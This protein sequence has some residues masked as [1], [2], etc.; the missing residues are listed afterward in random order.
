M[1]TGKA[2]I[3]DIDATELSEGEMAF[4]WL[5]QHG[6]VLKLGG[7]V[8]YLDPYLS[9]AES[10]TVRPLLRPEEIT[11]ADVITGSHDHGDHI[12]RPVWAELAKASPQAK[13]VAPRLI[14]DRGLAED[15]GIR[16]ERFVGLTDGATAEIAGVRITGVPAAHERLDV[17]PA[18]GLNPYLGYRIEGNGCRI[19]HAGDT[20][21]Y[22]G[23]ETRLKELGPFDLVFL[24]INGRDAERLASGC[25]GN[26]TY[27]EAVDLAGEIEPRLAVPAH[28]DMFANNSEDPRKFVDYLNVKF[29]RVRALI[30]RH[31]RRV[32]FRPG[33]E[34]QI[35]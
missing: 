6:F 26:M 25:I 10:R 35:A 13:F 12:D 32:R 4:W 24:P 18:T 31:G 5:G 33:G 2:L 14:L 20:C 8:L 16:A 15:L 34:P 19:Y 23:L 30:P 28:F 7:V 22:E 1:L 3:D 29:P 11:H 21:K 9:E 27:Q 17:D